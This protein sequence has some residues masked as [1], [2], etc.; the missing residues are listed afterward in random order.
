V[1]LVQR[2]VI[3]AALGVAVAAAILYW[4]LKRDPHVTQTV[5]SSAARPLASRPVHVRRAARRPPPSSSSPLPIAS[6]TKQT[7]RVEQLHTTVLQ[8]AVRDNWL[9]T[10]ERGTP[11]PPDRVRIVYDAPETL[12]GYTKGAYF[13]P[14]GPRPSDDNAEVNG[15]LLCEGSSFLYL[16]FEAYYRDD[17]RQWDVYPFPSVE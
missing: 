9:T 14:L 15:L 3:H 2:R 13:E 17:R 8:R 10:D 12:S 11:C 4:W 16:G 1:P 5:Q 6:G 7:S